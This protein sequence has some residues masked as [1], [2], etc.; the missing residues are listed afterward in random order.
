MSLSSQVTLD[1]SGNG[2]AYIKNDSPLNGLAVD[3]IT[4]RIPGETLR[5]T[6]AIYVGAVSDSSLLTLSG[7]GAADTALGPYYMGAGAELIVVWQGGTPGLTAET[8]ANGTVFTNPNNRGGD[9]RFTIPNAS[10]LIIPALDTI[11]GL[12]S[13][14]V[15]GDATCT[16][17]ATTEITVYTGPASTITMFT[18]AAIRLEGSTPTLTNIARIDLSRA[19]GRI[20]TWPRVDV[21]PGTLR[22]GGVLTYDGGPVFVPGGGTMRINVVLSAGSDQPIRWVLSGMRIIATSENND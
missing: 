11:A 16:Q 14:N 7:N 1:S 18:A 9:L 22:F 10:S 20:M 19:G 17:A 3:S 6:C 4:C 8:Y 21:Q 5:P 12:T 13:V 2:I 15:F